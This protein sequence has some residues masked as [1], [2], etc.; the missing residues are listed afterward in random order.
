MI[1]L[2]GYFRD[3]GI[4]VELYD[5]TQCPYFLKLFEGQFEL[6][7]S[8]GCPLSCI[9]KSVSD[10]DCHALIMLGDSRI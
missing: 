6:L 9:Y 2:N 1:V 5:E 8:I 4:K 10:G 7:S 3:K